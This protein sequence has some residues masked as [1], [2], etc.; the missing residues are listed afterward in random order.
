MRDWL[1]T[2]PRAAR[3][4]VEFRDLTVS[5]DVAKQG[6]GRVVAGSVT[7]PV[8]GALRN[9]IE[10]AADG[11]VLVISAP[12]AVGHPVCRIGRSEAA[13]HDHGRRL[14]PAGHNRARLITMSPQCD[15]YV[16]A[17]DQA[18]G[19]WLL[20]DTG[21]VIEGK[22]YVLD[23]SKARSPAPWS[24]AW[25]GLTL[26]AG[27]A[28]GEKN[29]PDPCNTGYLRGHY[30]YSDAIVIGSG[31]LREC[32]PDGA[33]H[34]RRD[35][36]ARTDVYLRRW[37]DGRMVQPDRAGRTPER[38]DEAPAGRSVRGQPGHQV[39]TPIDVVS[40]QPDLDLAGEVDHW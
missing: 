1:D 18:Y 24:P 13:R 27:T 25:R 15:F 37:C 35:Q 4:A 31:V 9:S 16:D 11:F 7:Y 23:L 33:C 5:L 30:A 21:M 2:D 22:G 8:A 40:I 34:L 10:I 12:R 32:L 36:P 26:G 14:V 17:P 38:A 20:G 39:T 19:P 28:S 3:F 29:V 6:L